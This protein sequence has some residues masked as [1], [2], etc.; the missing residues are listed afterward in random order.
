M[1]KK[2]F[3]S[4]ADA[5]AL[6]PLG[7]EMTRVVLV[8]MSLRVRRCLVIGIG[9]GKNR[10]EDGRVTDGT[11]HWAGGVLC[12][13]N[14]DNSGAANQA[15]RRF[16]AHEVLCIDDGLRMDP[17]VSVPMATAQRLAATAAAEPELDPEG[18]RLRT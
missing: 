11:S 8:D 12:V 5:S 13:R 18:L 16:D 3:A 14:R 6:K 1:W 2:E 9:H 15:D 17:S 10:E 7:V 4:H